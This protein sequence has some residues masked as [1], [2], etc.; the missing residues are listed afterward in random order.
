MSFLTFLETKVAAKQFRRSDDILLYEWAHES[1]HGSEAAMLFARQR[2]AGD[3]VGLHAKIG[4]PIVLSHYVDFAAKSM[5]A[6]VLATFGILAGR[7]RQD[8]SRP[9]VTSSEYVTRLRANKPLHPVHLASHPSSNGSP[10]EAPM[11]FLFVPTVDFLSNAPS[12]ITRDHLRPRYGLESL[13]CRLAT[14][15]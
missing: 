3:T 14:L 11:P 8:L 7:S 2:P 1:V 12:H 13:L 10:C 15:R 6:A 9:S 4:N 5:T